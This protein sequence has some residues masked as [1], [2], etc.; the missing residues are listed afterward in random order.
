MG[1]PSNGSE[2]DVWRKIKWN[3]W[4]SKNVSMKLSET[5]PNACIHPSGNLIPGLLPFMR[6]ELYGSSEV[7]PLNK[8]PSLSLQEVLKRMPAPVVNK[9][10]LHELKLQ[11]SQVQ[12]DGEA[13]LTHAVGKNYRD[14][15]RVRNGFLQRPPDAVILP[16]SHEDVVKLVDTAYKHDVCL[17]PF[18]GGTNV[19][20]AI[21]PDPA[22]TTRMTV[23]VDLRRMNKMMWVEK[24]SQ[25]AC[26]E[27]GVLGPDLEEQLSR[28]GFTFGHDPDSHIHSTLGGWAATRSSG[29]QS[30]KYGEMEDMIVSMT[31]V[32]PRGVVTTPTAPRAVGVSLKE[33][34]LGSEGVFGII[35]NLVI[36]VQNIPEQRICEGWLVASFEEG[37]EAFRQATINDIHPATLRLYDDDETRLS[38]SMKYKPTLV[39]SFLSKGIKAYAE[40]WKGMNMDKVCL[41][42][43]GYEG[44][45]TAVSQQRQA[46]HRHLTKATKSLCLGTG[47]GKN[48]L[49]KK[50][51]LPY[52]RDF[53]LDNGLWSD[54]L[55]TTT[56]YAR[57]IPLWRDVKQAVR[58]TWASLGVKGWIGCHLGHQYKT[59]TCLYFTFAGEQFDEKDIEER[60]LPLKVAAT[61]AIIK[62]RG[63]LA[64][65]HGVGYEHVPWME[66]YHGKVGLYI[67]QVIKEALDPKGI[68]N[69]GKLLPLRDD[70]NK[71]EEEN[72]AAKK[73]AMMFFKM[74]VMKHVTGLNK[75]KA[76]M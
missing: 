33:V 73:A 22:E 3:G 67:M 61:E 15:W 44:T 23:S 71:S 1:D 20:G 18:G 27:S 57:M 36:K 34:F 11:S 48:W 8:T 62:H 69:P 49:E 35:T 10:F 56:D 66:K 70:P 13:R 39:Q 26:F 46:F 17:I 7:K 43:V 32:T 50:Y 58:D 47:P 51:D 9:A 19:V 14:L 45:K 12:V 60:F 76:K 30:N 74:G 29:A 25:H 72:E 55:E 40:K 53:S 63:A 64:H 68:C 28:Y 2:A 16:H 65:H 6:Q 24:D 75:G 42:I 5:D 37:A 38:F 54:V 21:E 31:I 4:G 52:I 59:G 41:A